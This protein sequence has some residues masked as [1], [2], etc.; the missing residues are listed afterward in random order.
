M[1]A[2]PLGLGLDGGGSATRW[3]VADAAGAIVAA[4]ELPPVSGLLFHEEQRAAFAGMAQALAAAVPAGIGSVVAGITGLSAGSDSGGRAMAVLAEALGLPAHAVRVEQDIWIAYHA[5][6]RPGEGHLV[7]A[8]T[9]SVGLHIRADGTSLQVGGRGMLIDDAGSAFWIGRCALDRLFRA[10]DATGEA[11]GAMAD[12]VF[13]T[14]GARDWDAVRS[15]AY[16]GGRSGIALLAM[17][18][19]RAATAGDVAAL[20]L[21]R[22]AGTELARLAIALAGRI[23]ALPVALAGRAAGLHPAIIDAMRLAAPHLSIEPAAP[24]AAAAAARIAS[25]HHFIIPP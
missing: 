20:A 25:C 13:A 23:G 7:Y 6:F 1:T 4:G 9:G 5:A 15:Y 18:V 17:D 3:A 10:I 24:D 22:E 19:A 14:I 11:T 16:G 12:A 8:G 21:L 2:G